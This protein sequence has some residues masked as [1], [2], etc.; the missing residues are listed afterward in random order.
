MILIISPPCPQPCRPPLTRVMVALKHDVMTTPIIP[1]SFIQQRD[2][3]GFNQGS[4]IC[5]VHQI[6]PPRGDVGG[7]NFL[8][9]VTSGMMYNLNVHTCRCSN[10]NLIYSS[11]IY[12]EP[13]FRQY[14]C[15]NCYNDKIV[16]EII[17]YWY[18]LRETVIIANTL[19]HVIYYAYV[20]QLNLK[21]PIHI[22]TKT[23]K[24]EYSQSSS[25]SFTPSIS[26]TRWVYA[27]SRW[28][29]PS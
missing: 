24:K 7:R 13:A 9:H 26:R 21:Y 3:G 11:I 20:Q 14:N 6:Q 4:R 23:L 15:V 8:S 1:S 2:M 29:Y 12:C 17:Y 27:S 25:V 16:N 22:R 18:E 10:I 5:S 28:V 19:V